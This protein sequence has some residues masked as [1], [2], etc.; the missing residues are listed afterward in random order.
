MLVVIRPGGTVRDVNIVLR[1]DEQLPNRYN[2]KESIVYREAE[3]NPRDWTLVKPR[4]AVLPPDSPTLAQ[5]EL[6]IILDLTNEQSSDIL[7]DNVDI[8]RFDREEE[9]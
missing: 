4:H 3:D 7:Y 8:I 2:T 1:F 5:P 9:K 6:P